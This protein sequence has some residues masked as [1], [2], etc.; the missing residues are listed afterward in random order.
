MLDTGDGEIDRHGS[1]FKR[2][3]AIL[4]IASML[5]ITEKGHQ[6]ED[7]C[8][9]TSIKIVEVNAQHRGDI[10]LV[11]FAITFNKKEGEMEQGPNRVKLR[12]VL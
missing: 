10:M 1:A 6:Y 8:G 9:V 12:D 5:K 2:I 7:M 4:F 3:S 11:K